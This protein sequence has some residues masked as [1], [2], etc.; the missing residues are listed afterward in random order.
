MIIQVTSAIR[1]GQQFSVDRLRLK[2]VVAVAREQ[3]LTPTRIS[4]LIFK[5][6]RTLRRWE[7]QREAQLNDLR[8]KMPPWAVIQRGEHYYAV[9]RGFVQRT[10]F[11]HY[12][13]AKWRAEQV[14][15]GNY[16][17]F[18]D[19]DLP[20]YLDTH[21]SQLD[22]NK[23]CAPKRMLRETAEHTMEQAGEGLGYLMEILETLKDTTN[24]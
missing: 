6:E 2:T 14:A 3:G 8:V 12:H 7:K 4:Q 16:P 15:A 1:R 19:L 21:I 17:S 9:A 10:A 13:H 5:W 18:P 23:L 20:L 11:D 22:L 24:D